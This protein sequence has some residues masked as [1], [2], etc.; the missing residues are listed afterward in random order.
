MRFQ[1]ILKLA[2]T[3]F[4]GFSA[5]LASAEAEPL[6]KQLFGAKTLPAATRP[7]VHGFYSKGCFAGGVAIAPDGPN[8]QAMRL[9]RN[10]RWGHPVMISVLEKL[11][12]EAA[13]DGWRGLLVGDISQPRGGPMLT[14]HASHQ[15]GLDADIWFTEMPAKRMTVADRERISA[16]SMLKK[17]SLYVDDKKWTKGH[18]A[19]LRRAASYPEVER[20]LVHP[21]I[22]KK[23]CDTVRGDRS[24][25]NKVRPFWGHHYHFHVRIGCP[26]GSP[27]CKP[28]NPPPRSEGCDDTLAWWFTDEPWKPAK[29]PAKPKARD[30]MTMAALPSACRAVLAAPDPV[31][32]V[33]VTV[34]GAGG[35]PQA[36][37]A[38]L[39]VLGYQ[40]ESPASILSAMPS[41]SVPRPSNRPAFQ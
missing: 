22:K 5:T 25:L 4:L 3:A 28:Q 30:V 8:W 17:G 37:T 31:S 11:S 40:A 29:G 13:Q 19:V 21:G 12:R 33:A 18:E 23:L 2:A 35:V 16:I 6:A 32:E 34:T 38:E 14:G 7:A 20:L 9:S 10:R 26:A 41:A 1:R 15:L 39:P 27:G 36:A 24:W